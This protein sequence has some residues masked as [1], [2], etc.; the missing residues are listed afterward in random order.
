MFTMADIRDIAIQIE[1]NGEESYRQASTS[2]V[3]TKLAGIFRWLAEEE[4]RHAEYFASLSPDQPLSPEQS[5][6]EAMGRSLLQDMVRGKTFSLDQ[7]SLNSTENLEEMLDQ[8]QT[9]EQDT[10][11]FYQ[12]LRDIVDEPAVKQQLNAII[13]EEQRHAVIL[14]RMA[15]DERM[16]DLLSLPGMK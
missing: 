13:E 1:R 3:D 10:V 6:I 4:R 7:Q 9:F 8:A 11:L 16:D 12:F 5:E 15:G 14:A 2:V